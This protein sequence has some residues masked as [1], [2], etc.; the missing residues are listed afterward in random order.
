MFNAQEIIKEIE[1]CTNAPEYVLVSITE[2][3][4]ACWGEVA[5]M[6]DDDMI[7]M[8]V[9]VWGQ[10]ETDEMITGEQFLRRYA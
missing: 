9:D 10:D 4:E 3:G 7:A 1:A 6:N 2:N 5:A 8:T